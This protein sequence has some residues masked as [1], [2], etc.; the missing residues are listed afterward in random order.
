MNRLTAAYSLGDN[1]VQVLNTPKPADNRT[2]QTSGF[3][4]PIVFLW[5]GSEQQYKTRKGK[6][7]GTTGFVCSSTRSPSEQGRVFDK[8]TRK[9]P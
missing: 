2:R 5:P 7:A 8:K 9:C 4:V 6:V 3:F 1:P